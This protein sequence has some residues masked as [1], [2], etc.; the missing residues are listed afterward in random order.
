MKTDRAHCEFRVRRAVCG[1]PDRPGQRADA[2]PTSG[3]VA[4]SERPS[5]GGERCRA[6][7]IIEVMLAIGIFAMVLTAIYAMWTTILKGERVALQ[8]AAAVQRGR[9]A[10]Q[11]LEDAFLTVRMFTGNIKHYLFFADTAGDY[12]R[13][14]MASKL[15][16]GFP[17]VGY[18]GDVVVRRVTFEVRAGKDG[19][20]L[21]MT[22]APILQDTNA[23]PP[24][25]LVLAKDVSE[26]KLEF[27]DHLKGEWRDE[28]KST[29]QLPKLVQIRLGLGR[30]G[31][32]SGAAP[33]DVVARLV[34]IPSLA[35]AGDIQGVGAPPPGAF[36]F[37][38][39]LPPA[40]PGNN[41]P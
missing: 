10:I 3:G 28:W 33:Q 39:N 41:P 11:T 34:N 17:G 20:E 4:G 21:L 14:S 27:Y 12:A 30:V 15:P 22:Q 6:F 16:G 19:N 32:R 31:N 29:N 18:Y 5:R 40:N 8:A 38:T 35:V 37:P 9:L 23:V 25:A 36:P 1:L 13:L 7:T 2:R 24:Y 26:F